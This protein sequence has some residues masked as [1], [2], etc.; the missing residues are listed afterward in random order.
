MFAGFRSRTLMKSSM[1]INIALKKNSILFK[2]RTNESSKLL[3]LN[4]Y[5]MMRFFGTVIHIKLP[6]LGE[7]TKEA[8]MKEWFVKKGAEVKEF[9]D[10][11]EVF[12]DKLVAQIPST[13]KG[14]VKNI[15][16]SPDDIWAVGSTLADIEIVEEG[17]VAS[18]PVEN[19]IDAAV[20]KTPQ[21][22]TSDK[23]H[24]RTSEGSGDKVLATPVTRQYA[25]TKGVDINK[26][27][28]SGKDG[29]VVDSDIDAYL[30]KPSQVTHTSTPVWHRPS[31]RHEP[32][33]GIT[34]EDK[35]K[36]I[37]GIR[38]GMT[39]SMTDALNIPFFVFQDEYDATKLISLRKDL[40]V[41]NKNLTLL[42]FFVK[43]IS[44]ALRNHPGM[45]INVNPET[46]EDGYIYEYVIKHDH[47]IS[48]AVDSPNGLVVPNVKKVHTKSILEIN[49]D[50]L[51]L[52]DKANQGKLTREDYEGGTF[53]VSSVGNLAGTYFVPTILRPQ[54][55]I[56]AIG[57][58]RKV[59]KYVGTNSAGYQ[60]VPI[61]AINFSFSWDH[62]VI[63]GAT[64]ARFSED[65][66]KLVENPQNMLLNMN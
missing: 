1:N 57:K 34:D 23:D 15:Y 29:R 44:I 27:K 6:D 11:W 55:A 51:L 37:G 61:D 50:L 32:L 12:T 33:K 56:V 46:D 49:E 20:S 40:K 9:Q 25:K 48:I 13:H 19:K 63:D 30:S 66:R 52:R 47:N 10:L 21:K 65:I 45:N 8:T 62:R 3:I 59:P 4:H 2:N 35:V 18:T 17:N 31:H 64:C 5:N 22:L 36:R 42:P 14:V 43:A 16:F 38:K 54:G 39:K 28:G 26:I 53:S 41:T 58:S 60:W 24:H 7:G